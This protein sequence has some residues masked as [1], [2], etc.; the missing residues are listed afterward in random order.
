MGG[1]GVHSYRGGLE[2]FVIVGVTREV[3]YQTVCF[4]QFCFSKT[5][6]LRHI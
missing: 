6:L 3:G 2:K 4:R 5:S 1:I